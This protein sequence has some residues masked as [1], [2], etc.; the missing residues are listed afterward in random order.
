MFIFFFWVFD[1]PPSPLILGGHNFLI[2]Y[3]FSKFL[4]VLDAPR[5]GLQ[6]LFGHHKQKNPPLANIL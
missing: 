1:P 3:L 2:S 5:G 6:V 4:S